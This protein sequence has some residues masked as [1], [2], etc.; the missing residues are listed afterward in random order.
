MFVYLYLYIF[1]FIISLF[2]NKRNTYIV[3]SILVVVLALFAGTRN[4]D[5]DNDYF[6]YKEFFSEALRGNFFDLK[7]EVSVFV[8]PYVISWFTGDYARWSFVTFAFISLGIK[9][10]AIKD[11]RFFVL[12]IL[13]YVGNLFFIQDMT[14][15]RASVSSGILLWSLKD[16]EERRDKV[17]F[18]KIGLALL[19]HSSSA[20]FIIIWFVSKF[21]IKYK[22]LFIALGFSLLVPLL[23][24]NFIKILHLDSIYSKAAVYLTAKD[25]EDKKINL[26]NFKILISLFYLVILYWKRKKINYKGFDLM[27]KIHCLSLIFFFLFSTTGLT[28]SLRTFELLSIIQI[29]LFPLLIL[30]FHKKLR[31]FAYF[32]VLATSFVFFYYI[33]FISELFKEYSSWLF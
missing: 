3:C 14:T 1:S 23:N 16:L 21:N 32:I 11:Y 33:I 17:F 10:F 31:I 7:T 4:E 30:A 26:F 8:I 18:A 12:A 9:I 25:Y 28:F 29:V 6:L 13:L 27:L 20:I 2:K 24:L 19:F 15:I 5:I 22:W